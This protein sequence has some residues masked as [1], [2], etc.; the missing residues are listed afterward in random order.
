QAGC[1]RVPSHRPEPAAHPGH[2]RHARVL[3]RDAGRVVAELPLHRHPAAGCQLGPHGRP[4]AA[5]PGRRLVAVG[6]AGPG[7]RD[8]HGGGDRAGRVA[9]SGDRPRT[10]LAAAG[11]AAASADRVDRAAALTAM[12][13]TECA[14]LTAVVLVAAC[15]Q[16]S[17]GFGMGMFAAP[18][19][20][21]IDT[22]LLPVIVITLSIVV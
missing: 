12:S 18:F 7:D 13:G 6:A 11:E 22:T 4:G 16:G 1:D 8:H 2:A 10:A 9:A 3:L 14:L 17:I 21:L 20:A 5:V 19:I 15:L